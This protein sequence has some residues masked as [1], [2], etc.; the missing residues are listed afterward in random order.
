MAMINDENAPPD[1]NID[2]KTIITFNAGQ[3][4]KS[5]K[6]VVGPLTMRTGKN[7]TSPTNET[8]CLP[9]IIKQDE[10]ESLSSPGKSDDSKIGDDDANSTNMYSTDEDFD[11]EQEDSFDDDVPLAEDPFFGNVQAETCP[12]QPTK[13]QLDSIARAMKEDEAKDAACK[14]PLPE[15]PGDLPALELL[16]EHSQSSFDDPFTTFQPSNPLLNEQIHNAVEMVVEVRSSYADD[17][18]LV[19]QLT[20]PLY[21]MKLKFIEAAALDVEPGALEF[22]YNDLLIEDD[23]TAKKID[24]TA[25]SRI[26]CQKV[27]AM[28]YAVPMPITG[29]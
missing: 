29:W 25:E 13:E 17:V 2:T 5:L 18:F 16:D 3:E 22:F 21:E 14:Q 26:Q 27:G 10:H 6:R 19:V 23:Y 15:S 9:T 8:E 7:L 28:R 20:E 12:R 24:L 1:T 4:E 11:D